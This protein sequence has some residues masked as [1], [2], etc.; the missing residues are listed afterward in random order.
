MEIRSRKRNMRKVPVVRSVGR[1]WD[2]S[3]TTTRLGPSRYPF[4]LLMDVLTEDVRMNVPGSMMYAYAD[5]I[6]LRG[7]DEKDTTA[8]LE[9]WTRALEDRGMMII[10]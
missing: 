2:G 10:I 8:Y 5:Y 7:D 6:V 9:T 4:L 1:L 3:R